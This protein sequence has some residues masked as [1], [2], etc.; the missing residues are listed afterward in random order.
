MKLKYKFVMFFLLSLFVASSFTTQLGA[1]TLESSVDEDLFLLIDQTGKETDVTT[2]VI[3]DEFEILHFF[4]RITYEND[5][6]LI[7]HIINDAVNVVN[8]D[9]FIHDFFEV[10][11]IPGG[12]TLFYAFHAFYGI[13]YFHH[14]LL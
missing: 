11:Q 14:R 2:R 6:F 9:E 10:F 13:S 12:V 1:D 5:S 7:L 4:V 3:Y 8:T